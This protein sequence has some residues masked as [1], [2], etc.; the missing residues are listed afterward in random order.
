MDTWLKKISNGAAVAVGAV[1]VLMV[2]HVTA[3]VLLRVLFGMHIPGTMEVVTYYY[4]VAAV[5]VGIF[6]CTADDVHIRVDVVAQFFRGRFR[7]VVDGI[8]MVAI[9]VYFAIFSYGLYLQAV[10]SWKRQETVDAIVAELAVWPSRWLAVIGI[11]LA[12]MAS[13]YWLYQFVSSWG[14]DQEDSL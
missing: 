2:V 1:T 13:L 11:S 5:F 12:L 7:R 8:G 9:T 14:S 3:E 4:M 10:R 6:S